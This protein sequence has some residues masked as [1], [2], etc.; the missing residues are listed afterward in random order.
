M[1]AEEGRKVVTEMRQACVSRYTRRVPFH[2]ISRRGTST[3][4][5]LI[6]HDQSGTRSP[7]RSVV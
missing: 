1:S 4:G 3:L 2:I 7:A 6:I 5:R